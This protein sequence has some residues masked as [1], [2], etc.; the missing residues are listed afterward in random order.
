MQF[1]DADGEWQYD[2]SGVI[3]ST[4]YQAADDSISLEQFFSRPVVLGNFTWSSSVLLYHTINPWKLFCEQKRVINRLANYRLGRFKL[5]LKFMVNGSPFYYGRAIAHYVPLY[6]EDDFTQ[7]RAL[8]WQDNIAA[9]QT[10]HVYIDPTTCSGG[11]IDLPFIWRHNYLDLVQADWNGMGQLFIRHVAPLANTTGLVDNL[12][13]TVLAWAS[14]VSLSAPTI[15]NPAGIV[16]QGG[17]RHD[18]VS[19]T[20]ASVAAA[21]G[22]LSHVPVIG[23][24]AT[25]A[26]VVSSA[27]A[28]R[29]RV[30]GFSR[31]GTARNDTA[32]V[33]PF[34]QICNTNTY[35]TSTKLTLDHQQGVT[36]DPTVVGAEPHD[37]MQLK[38]IATRESLL[39]YFV[40]GSGSGVYG[41]QLFQCRVQPTLYDLYGG[42][43]IHNLPCSFAAIPFRSWRGSMI[44]RFSIIASAFHKGRIRIFYEPSKF[45]ST[46]SGQ[47]NVNHSVILDL[48]QSREVTIKVG[49]GSPYTYCQVQTPSYSSLPYSTYA[50]PSVL[51]PSSELDPFNGYI[52]VEVVTPLSNPNPAVGNSVYVLVHAK[53]GDDIEF[54]NLANTQASFGYR[55][56][57]DTP[58]PLVALVN[59]EEI[60]SQQGS[61]EEVGPSDDHMEPVSEQAEELAPDIVDSDHT[62]LICFGDPVV[63][64]RQILKRYSFLGVTTY[65]NTR[66]GTIT[67]TMGTFFL[68]EPDFPA[69]RGV[70]I[71]SNC[72]Y[73]SGEAAPLNGY[74]YFNNTFLNYFTPAFV[75]RRG[76]IRRTY[77]FSGFTNSSTTSLSGTSFV[78][79]LNNLQVERRPGAS[80]AAQA[81]VAHAEASP[82]VMYQQMRRQSRFTPGGAATQME[83]FGVLSVELP[84]HT[85]VRFAQARTLLMYTNS[86]VRGAQYHNITWNRSIANNAI[87]LLNTYVAAADDFSLSFFLSVPIMYYSSDNQFT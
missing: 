21:A 20:A 40:W 63:S 25:A 22:A 53:A 7:N 52:G 50:D 3:D 5:H 86:E 32:V 34:P 2:A 10:P 31:P 77:A 36:V 35:D 26:E 15:Q 23:K 11:Q 39:T 12:T 8:V 75:C 27:I 84:Y 29:A 9:S 67:G 43:E 79:L 74:L 28:D 1:L 81:Y 37:E 80:I 6:L 30:L 44:F 16:P 48:N 46:T 24:Y 33:I 13:I 18:T 58:A 57:P 51:A 62:N 69:Y 72:A 41:T 66:T 70:Y 65:V 17:E 82:I 47:Y 4:R 55:P 64:I 45:S 71:D 85:H 73:T 61:A 49:W 68:R 54:A 83:R 59:G 19:S 38:T 14:E 60:I 56:F 87:P 76:G 42:R 78:G